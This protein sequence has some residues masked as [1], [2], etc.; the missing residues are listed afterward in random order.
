VLAT[1][2]PAFVVAHVF[3]FDSREYGCLCVA[4]LFTVLLSARDYARSQRPSASR[5][6]EP[7]GRPVGGVNFDFVAR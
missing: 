6:R 4:A 3:A 5:A 7:R 1:W 2:A